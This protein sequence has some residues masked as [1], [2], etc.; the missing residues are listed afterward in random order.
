MYTVKRNSQ[1]TLPTEI[2]HARIRMLLVH[3]IEFDLMNHFADDTILTGTEGRASING[4]HKITQRICI[5]VS[6]ASTS[7]M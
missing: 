5:V 2:R 3:I 6:E 7:F 1:L 4:K